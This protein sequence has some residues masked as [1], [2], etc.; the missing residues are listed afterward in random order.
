MTLSPIELAASS[1]P[2]LLLPHGTDAEK[3]A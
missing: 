3:V 2:R 1:S